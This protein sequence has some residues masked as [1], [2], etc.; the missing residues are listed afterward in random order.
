MKPLKLKTILTA[1]SFVAIS[2]AFAQNDSS[3]TNNNTV[4]DTVSVVSPNEP[5]ASP[6]AI[7][8]VS[9][10]SS[11]DHNSM[12][13]NSMTKE[14]RKLKKAAK[15]ESKAARRSGGN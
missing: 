10:D 15:K 9:T 11:M 12:D 13:N 3:S 14:E 6:T 8:P 5:Q 1:L 2:G 4:T 7:D